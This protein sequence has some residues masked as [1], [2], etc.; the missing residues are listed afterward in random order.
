MQIDVLARLLEKPASPFIL[1]STG[2][3]FRI[4]ERFVTRATGEQKVVVLNGRR[5]E[6]WTGFFAEFI[7]NFELSE[8]FG[9]N[10]DALAECITDL[11][12]MKASGYV[13]LVSASDR[14]LFR[15]NDKIEVLLDQA[16]WAGEHWAT[17]VRIGQ[18]WDRDA[19]PFHT[20]LHFDAETDLGNR[21][22]RL[23]FQG[24]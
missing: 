20:L 23:T 15:E 8:Y 21:V 3:E 22:T 10:L 4:L 16:E 13:M 9:H 7:E 18:W 14:I 6:T 2:L 11:S 17:P 24:G 19:I 1:S 5:M 12:W